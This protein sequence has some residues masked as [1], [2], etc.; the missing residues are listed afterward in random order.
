MEYLLHILQLLLVSASSS[1]RIYYM[2]VFVLL[3]GDVLY[4][5]ASGNDA[6][7]QVVAETYDSARLVANSFSSPTPFMQ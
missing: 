4:F 6:L 2:G 5:G 1:R 7:W 3:E